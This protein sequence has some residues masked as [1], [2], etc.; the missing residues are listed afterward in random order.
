M[1]T[2][3]LKALG[4]SGYSFVIFG[5]C[6]FLPAWSFGFWQA[7]LYLGAIFCPALLITFYMLKHNP[8]LIERRL[9]GGAGNERRVL[10]RVIRLLS[11][12]FWVSSLIL[13]AF[14]H[15]LHWSRVP[16]TLAILADIAVIAGWGV[17]FLV[18]KENNYASATVE[19]VDS[20]KVITTGPYAIVRHPM[21]SGTVLLVL[22]AP[23]ALGSWWGLAFSIPSS[24]LIVL[25]LLDE[26]KLLVHTLDGY[27]TY[28]DEVPWR[29]VPR[30]W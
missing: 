29:L 23:M 20:Q 6:L 2:L 8:Q 14:D 22:L 26:E 30:L 19:I 9:K 3:T 27:D 17:I 24:F 12:S 21:Y 18:F 7:W 15:R 5:L 13:S 16:A 28:R 25:R 10:Q 1:N 11:P 4:V